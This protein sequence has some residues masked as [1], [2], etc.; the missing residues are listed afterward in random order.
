MAHKA[1]DLLSQDIDY[2]RKVEMTLKRIKAYAKKY[3]KAGRGVTVDRIENVLISQMD[4][5]FEDIISQWADLD[6]GTLISKLQNRERDLI[7]KF[8]LIPGT[9][10]DHPMA[11]STATM[12]KNMTLKKRFEVMEEL[13]RLGGYSGIGPNKLYYMA[14]GSHIGSKFVAP[15]Q[16]MSHMDPHLTE[17][18]KRAKLNTQM[19]SSMVSP[20]IGTSLSDEGKSK[21]E[22]LAK[23]KALDLKKRPLKVQQNTPFHRNLDVKTAGRRLYERFFLPQEMLAKEASRRA[24]ELKAKDYYRQLFGR[25]PFAHKYGSKQ[26]KRNKKLMDILPFTYNDVVDAIDKGEDLPKLDADGL[27]VFNAIKGKKHIPGKVLDGVKAGLANPAVSRTLRFGGLGITVLGIGGNL[28]ARAEGGRRLEELKKG[29]TSIWSPEY[30]RRKEAA[31]MKISG[32]A[33]LVGLAPIGGIG[34]GAAALLATGA[35]LDQWR[36]HDKARKLEELEFQS[37]PSKYIPANTESG[38]AELKQWDQTRWEKAIGIF[39]RSQ[40]RWNNFIYQ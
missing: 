27:A 29:D 37:G 6:G 21:K 22:L 36:S 10:G 8:R 25:N 4:R 1:V 15:G 30:W 18:G 26:W 34:R 23:R 20:S 17:V 2:L 13:A 33:G 28:E 9:E 7:K 16:V 32:E 3:K 19:W 11:I 35:S 24:S 39:Q 14:K 38:V 40:R 5:A 31:N 12:T